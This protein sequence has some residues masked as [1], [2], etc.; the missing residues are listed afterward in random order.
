MATETELG[1]EAWSSLGER[2]CQGSGVVERPKA[3]RETEGLDHG[4]K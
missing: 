1:I 2:L 4:L 3:K